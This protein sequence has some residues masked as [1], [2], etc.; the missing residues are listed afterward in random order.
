MRKTFGWKNLCDLKLH[1]CTLLQ[2]SDLGPP[3]G[4]NFAL[5]RALTAPAEEK[6]L[7]VANDNLVSVVIPCYNRASLLQQAIASCAIQT[8]QELEVIVVDDGSE[9]DLR[10][11]VDAARASHCLGER[12]KYLRQEKKG[13]AAARN[14]GLGMAAGSFVQ[15]LD[16]DDLL[17]PEKIAIQVAQLS[18][19]EDLDM[20]YCLDE[21]FVETV[22]DVRVLWNVPS[23]SD[24]REDLDR[25][26]ME[27]AVWQTGS[28]LWKRASLARFGPWDEALDCWQDWEFHVGALCAGV[29]CE[30]T[31]R[32]LQY[33]RRHHD[34][35][36]QTVPP[37]VR[38]RSCYR[39]GKN[40]WQ[41][42]S[43]HG[44]LDDRRRKLLL[45]YFFRHLI[46]LRS[47][48]EPEALRLQREM[49]T[50]MVELAPT[51][52]RRLV[53]RTMRSLVRTRLFELALNT[54]LVQTSYERRQCSL[55]DVVYAGFLPLPPTELNEIVGG[56]MT[57]LGK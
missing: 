50:F 38:Q 26:L 30:P 48:T 13:G 36:T 42:L 55:R 25:F 22:G 16:S 51:S 11:V 45:D 31:G 40:A 4:Y 44:R 47:V 3:T 32:V 10:A 49:L 23:R 6:A 12:L 28:P 52:R 53:I 34:P 18:S 19:R 35:R 56:H 46:A 21:Q 8:Y 15:F 9:D 41:H 39:A 14:T 2:A 5:G 7:K 33:I 37:L 20:V 43:R 27:D 1:G 29:R 54:Y 57:P 24:V 17:H